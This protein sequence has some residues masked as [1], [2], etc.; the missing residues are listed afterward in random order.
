MSLNSELTI[1]T[2]SQ[3]AKELD[4]SIKHDKKNES[5]PKQLISK[6]NKGH[7]SSDADNCDESSF[8]LSHIANELKQIKTEHLKMTYMLENVQK[9]IRTN[10][11]TQVKSS[12]EIGIQCDLL[13]QYKQ[14]NT[15]AST[16]MD[17]IKEMQSSIQVLEEENKYL[18]SEIKQTYHCNVYKQSNKGSKIFHQ[19]NMERKGITT[20]NRFDV[21]SEFSDGNCIS[22]EDSLKKVCYE[23]SKQ[24]RVMNVNQLKLSSSSGHCLKEKANSKV[25][26]NIQKNSTVNSK[27]SEEEDKHLQVTKKNSKLYDSLK[28]VS[29]SYEAPALSIFSDKLQ[30]CLPFKKVTIFS[31]S[32]GRHLGVHMRDLAKGNCEIY[33]ICKPNAKLPDIFPQPNSAHSQTSEKNGIILIAGTN[34]IDAGEERNIYKDLEHSLRNVSKSTKI[35]LCTIPKRHDLPPKH[36]TNIEIIHVNRHLGKIESLYNNIRLFNMN[37]LSRN[38]FTRHGMHLTSN[39]K[40]KF[41][42]ELMHHLNLFEDI[43]NQSCKS[44]SYGRDQGATTIPNHDERA[45]TTAPN[46]DEEANTNTPSRCYMRH[47]SYVKAVKAT[48]LNNSIVNIENNFL[49][50]TSQFKYN[51]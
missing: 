10:N 7:N 3:I 13:I 28:T 15:S 14:T 43:K 1:K 51:L 4:Q 36:K 44:D 35:L 29:E 16:N 45:T 31:D 19:P 17:L 32:H 9:S 24:K 33:S 12:T 47:E 11:G 18:K 46:H 26:K 2:R 49:D 27:L 37:V 40:K 48:N 38:L 6:N 50:S 34:D 22:D 5:S 30:N 42:N 8:D 39:G 23:V 25:G 41:A 20:Q 21:L